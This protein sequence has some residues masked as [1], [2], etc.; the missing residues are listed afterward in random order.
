M[1]LTPGESHNES[2]TE[3]AEHARQAL[4]QL[5]MRSDLEAFH[6]LLDLSQFTSQCVGESARSL[7]SHGSWSE[8]AEATG[9]TKQA[10]WSRWRV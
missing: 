3:L 1:T 4:G 2:V 5:A 8:V 6:A 7:A 9:T 10:A